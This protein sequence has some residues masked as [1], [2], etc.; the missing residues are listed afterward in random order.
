ML[1]VLISQIKG[2]IVFSLLTVNILVSAVQLFPLV[3]TKIVIPLQRWRSLTGKILNKIASNWVS[4]NSYVIFSFFPIKWTIK[5]VEKLKMNDWYLLI[6]NHQSW[7]DIFVLQ[8]IMHGK[9]PFIKFFLKKELIWVPVMG[10]AW[11]A[12]DFPF[13]KRYRREEI[14]RKPE[15]KGVDLEITRR[16][17]EKFKTEYVAVM[18]FPEGTRFTKEKHD[19]HKSPY[20][21]LLRPRAGGLSFII[22]AMGKRFHR[23]LNITIV[24]PGGVK[25]MWEFFCGMVKKIDVFVETLPIPEKF[26]SA[27]PDNSMI[28]DEFNEWLNAMWNRKDKLIH[29]NL[30]E[31]QTA[32]TRR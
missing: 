32:Q 8:K 27:D 5:G 21:H 31:Y 1:N 20:R 18:T 13:M 6:A 2:C 9:I 15:L 26:I 24:Y 22:S 4:F 7:V 29:S 10:P 17:C 3:L 12:L 25:N 11:W 19:R 16:A 14:E 28:K 23:L 30:A